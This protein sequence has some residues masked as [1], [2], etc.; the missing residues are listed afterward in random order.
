MNPRAYG[1]TQL[2]SEVPGTMRCLRRFLAVLVLK[3]RSPLSPRAYGDSQ[4]EAIWPLSFGFKNFF[5]FVKFYQQR[6]EPN[7]A[8]NPHG[9]VEFRR[10][11]DT[12][13]ADAKR[14]PI[15]IPMDIPV[16]SWNEAS[17]LLS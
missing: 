2:E 1:D 16:G 6:F 10:L 12:A 13:A 14:P 17:F 8:A 3:V 11:P 5:I 9:L 15:A 4:P 7:R